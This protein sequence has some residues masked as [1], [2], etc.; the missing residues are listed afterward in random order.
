MQKKTLRIIFVQLYINEQILF[1]Q[2]LLSFVIILL[3]ITSSVLF[4]FYE[5]LINF[6]LIPVYSQNNF[7]LQNYKFEVV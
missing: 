5:I 7:K 6:S 4:E 3:W 1:P 2:K